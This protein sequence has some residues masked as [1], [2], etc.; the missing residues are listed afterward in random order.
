MNTHTEASPPGQNAESR[1]PAK[2]TAPESATKSDTTNYPYDARYLSTIDAT[3][4]EFPFV[5]AIDAEHKRQRA[6]RLAELEATIEAYLYR[7]YGCF[8]RDLWPDRAPNYG[9]KWSERTKSHARVMRW[10]NKTFAE[11]RRTRAPLPLWQ[12]A[13]GLEV[14][15]I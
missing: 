6:E 8:S 11:I 5:P 7:N 10:M 4:L 9:C 2:G 13:K 12:L 1:S 3:F 14:A 15:T